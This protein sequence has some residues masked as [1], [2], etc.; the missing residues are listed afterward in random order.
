[1]TDTTSDSV[2]M[3]LERHADEAPTYLKARQ[4]ARDLE[5]SPKAVAQYLHQLQDELDG[6]TLT[7]WGRSKSITWQLQKETQ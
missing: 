4:I 3:Y 5:A 6:I 1:M 7:Q 2:R